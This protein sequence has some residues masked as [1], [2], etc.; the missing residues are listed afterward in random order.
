[1][2]LDGPA[3]GFIV[4]DTLYD[5]KSDLEGYIGILDST[6]TIHVVFRGSSS[7]RNWI[8]DFEIK[9]VKYDTFPEC[10]CEI[11]YGFYNAILHL[12]DQTI[13]T[14]KKLIKKYNYKVI[15]NGHSLGA[16]TSQIMCMELEAIG[17]KTSVYNYGQPRGGDKNYA[18]FSNNIIKD[19]YRFTHYK[20][21][22]P[23]IPPIELGYYHSCG[24]IYENNDGLLYECSNNVC[25]DP[26]CSDQ[27][28]LYETNFDN[29]EIYLEHKLE[30]NS[31]VIAV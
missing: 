25:E 22:V 21:I 7:V 20:D 16:I 12:K 24:E 19:Y 26:N 29:H 10:N 17:I 30:C 2:I 6:K 15:C 14:I 18:Q 11:H 31:S 3:K 5:Y 13:N 23:H 28:K 1:M 9:K 27:F 4:K 8:D